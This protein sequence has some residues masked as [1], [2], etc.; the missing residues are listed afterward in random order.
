LNLIRPQY[1]IPIH[2][3]LRHLTLHARLAQELG[4]PADHTLVVENGYVLEFD[5]QTGRIGERVPG[6]YVFVDGSGVGDVGPAVLRDREILARD[7]FVI[8]VIRRD[9]QSGQVIGTPEIISRGFVFL[10]DAEDL[11]AQAKER[12]VRTLATKKRRT[13]TE[14]IGNLSQRQFAKWPYNRTEKYGG[15]MGKVR[16]LVLDVLKPLEPTIIEL[17]EQ[18]SVL[19]GVEAVNISIY[20]IDR[21]VENAKIT[22]EGGDLHYDEVERVIQENGGTVHSIDEVVAGKIIIDDSATPQD[23]YQG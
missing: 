14:A 16:R 2:G 17:A 7:G 6:G 18:L 20:E 8:V 23:P 22:I 4:I 12:M 19:P 5:G 15:V 11:L 1:F 21:R 3:E 13:K 10:R 9:A